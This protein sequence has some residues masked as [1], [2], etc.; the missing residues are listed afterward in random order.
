MHL[1]SSVQRLAIRTQIFEH[2]RA[3]IFT[4]QLMQYNVKINVQA[5]RVG[6]G[7][8]SAKGLCGSI[9][10]RY[11]ALLWF[12]AKITQIEYAIP[13]AAI[14]CSALSFCCRW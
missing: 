1:A 3:A 12:A 6:A 4:G 8:Q 13:I 2:S 9:A 5:D 14:A 11:A 10:G 7:N